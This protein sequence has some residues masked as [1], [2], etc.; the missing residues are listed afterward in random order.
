ML[1]KKKT[2]I[3][4]I[5]ANKAA[6]KPSVQTSIDSILK[7]AIQKQ[8]TDIF[9]IPSAD[10]EKKVNIIFTIEHRSIVM[11]I[12][13]SLDSLESIISTIDT[14]KTITEVADN[15]V[16]LHPIPV[17]EDKKGV[18]ISLI[19]K[20]EILTKQ[21]LSLI[22]D[23]GYD[24]DFIEKITSSFHIKNGI[25][26]FSSP[27]YKNAFTLSHAISSILLEENKNISVGFLVNKQQSISVSHKRAILCKHKDC[28]ELISNIA[29][30]SRTPVKLLSVTEPSL[31]DTT[32]LFKIFQ[33][34]FNDKN[35]LMSLSNNSAFGIYFF[36]K[37]LYGISYELAIRSISHSSNIID[38]NRLCPHCKIEDKEKQNINNI[39]KLYKDRTLYPAYVKDILSFIGEKD[40]DYSGYIANES[41]CE[42]CNY[43]GYNGK[44]PIVEYFNVSN[45]FLMFLKE[46]ERS[47]EDVENQACQTGIGKNR[48]YDF[49]KKIKSGET[50]A[51][52]LNLRLIL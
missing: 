2:T 35:I 20:K 46:K 49:I 18:Y 42:Q 13:L 40:Q 25:S 23:F 30:L 24:N 8:A 22:N 21:S 4:N 7:E 41:G 15:F 32:T 51:S 1:L 14:N 37:E 6:Q 39:K 5:S 16:S 44:I 11:D 31:L 38:V 45:S 47:I 19:K 34:S 9:L 26:V 36:L 12:S 50:D 43:S 17:S 10:D 29:S 27:K 52:M 28:D 48:I 3:G 33:M